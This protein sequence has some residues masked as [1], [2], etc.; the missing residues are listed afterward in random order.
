MQKHLSFFATLV[1]AIPAMLIA[2][3]QGGKTEFAGL[4]VSAALLPTEVVAPMPV[5]LNDRSFNTRLKT[6][7]TIVL[8]GNDLI[9]EQPN[10]SSSGIFFMALDRLELR[11]KGE[12]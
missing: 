12:L 8:D 1:L 9:L 7:G 3:G 10:Y 2:E 11:N 6:G 5:S 4:P